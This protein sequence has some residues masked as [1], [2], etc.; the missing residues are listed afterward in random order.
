MTHAMATCQSIKV[1]EDSK[2]IGDPMDLKMFEFTKWKIEEGVGASDSSAV[3]SIVR[4]DNSKPPLIDISD[5]ISGAAIIDLSHTREL[6]I[7]RS[8]DFS[9]KLRRMS[10]VVKQLGAKDVFI[11][12]KGAPEII[13]QICIP[14]TS[15]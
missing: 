8:F 2:T 11:Y 10:V 9:S 4:P 15:K 14:E 6:G 3:I 13:S 7:I 5:M 1:I 12:T